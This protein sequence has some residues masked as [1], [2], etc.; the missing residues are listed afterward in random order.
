[1]AETELDKISKCFLRCTHF[2]PRRLLLLRLIRTTASSLSQFTPYHVR[3]GLS[4]P[5][6]SR[7][8]HLSPLQSRT[9]S[10]R[11][12]RS[13]FTGCAVCACVFERYS[14]GQSSPMS[15]VLCF[16]CTNSP[17]PHCRPFPYCFPSP[18]SVRECSGKNFLCPDIDSTESLFWSTDWKDRAAFT[19][20]T[21]ARLAAY[22]ATQQADGSVCLVSF[23]AGWARSEYRPHLLPCLLRETHAG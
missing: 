23:G 17:F 13:T 9:M 7:F 3:R 1:M 22:I 19:H 15:H 20:V 2:A 5:Q 10:R 6:F 4:D 8:F 16:M 14:P 11:A 18:C 21:T 12:C